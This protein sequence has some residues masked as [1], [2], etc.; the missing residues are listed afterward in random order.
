MLAEKIRHEFIRL[1][2]NQQVNIFYSLANMFQQIANVGGNCSDAEIENLH[3]VHLQSF[4]FA[5]TKVA[6]ASVC[7]FKHVGFAAVRI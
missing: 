6:V 7:H 4:L 3:A 1:V 5:A 2:I